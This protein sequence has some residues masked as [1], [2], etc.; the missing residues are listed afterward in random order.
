MRLVQHGGRQLDERRVRLLRARAR[1]QRLPGPRRPVEE[2]SLRRADP[3]LGEELRTRQRKHHGF[4]ELLD[5]LVQA[6]DV[7]VVV[8][9]LL[10]EEHRLHALVVLRGEQLVE[11]ACVFVD[12]DEV[13]WVDFLAVE[14]SFASDEHFLRDKGHPNNKPSFELLT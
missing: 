3:Q 7:G 5:L 6:A 14:H 12:S 2:D 10:F 9:G 11:H 4:L 13:A 1:Q 8:G